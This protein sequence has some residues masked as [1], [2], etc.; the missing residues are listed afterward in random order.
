MGRQS[1]PGK[2]ITIEGTEGV[3]KTT[4]IEFIK[5]WLNE[6]NIEFIATREPGG[7]PLAEQLRGLLLQ[8]RDEAVDETAELL[9]VFAARAQHLNQVII[10]A[11]E[12]GKWVLCDRFTDATYAYQGG[13][14]QM[15]TETISNLENLVQRALRPDAVLLLDIPVEQGLERARG[16]GELDRFEQEDIAFFE[17]VR[18]AYLQRAKNNDDYHVLDASQPLEQVQAQLKT[19]LNQLKARLV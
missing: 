17:R 5:Q 16:R 18:T 13:G 14:R 1:Q 3:G 19:V 15:N 10:P 11:L 8:P 9:M 7:T 6:N 4:N 2:F 12:H